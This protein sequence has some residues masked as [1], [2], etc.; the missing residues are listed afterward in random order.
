MKDDCVRCT[1][2]VLEPTKIPVD[3]EA[4]EKISFPTNDPC[5]NFRLGN[6]NYYSIKHNCV[7]NRIC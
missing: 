1:L 4:K 5:G 7:L 6:N 3:C 2:S